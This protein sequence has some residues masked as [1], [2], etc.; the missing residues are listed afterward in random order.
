MSLPPS[1]MT[2]AWAAQLT[3]NLHPLACWRNACRSAPCALLFL[4]FSNGAMKHRELLAGDVSTDWRWYSMK[5]KVLL[6][7]T[8]PPHWSLLQGCSGILWQSSKFDRME[9]LHRGY[10]HG[11]A[12]VLH[13]L[14]VTLGQAMPPHWSLLR[15][16]PKDCRDVVQLSCLCAGDV[17]TDGRWCFMIFKVTL[18]QAMPPHWSLL[19]TGPKDCHDVVQ[20]SCLCAGDV[21]TDGR[22][23]FM[24]FKVTL[25]QAMPPHWSLLRT[26]P[27]DCHAVVQASCLCAGDVSTDGRWCFMIFKVTLGQAMPPHWSLLRTGPKDCRD[28]VQLS[29]LC[30]GDV[31]TDGR[32]CF[33]IFKVTLGQAMP[34]HWSLL[35]RRLEAICPSTHGDHSMWRYT[36]R[37]RDTQHPFLL[38]VTSYDRRG[39]LHGESLLLPISSKKPRLQKPP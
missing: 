20:A 25:G 26:G 17:S 2:L 32:W 10:E 31:S 22:W 29:C 13:D 9:C 19:R 15:T 28:V 39:F 38:Q 18:V 34:P 21:S 4:K 16:A 11:R 30:A 6:E 8:M 5:F 27:K 12:V 14:K 35:R 37:T 23:C 36:S 1:L 24:I 3:A 7:Q 33:M